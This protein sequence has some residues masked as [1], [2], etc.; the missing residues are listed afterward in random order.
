MMKSDYMPS[1]FVREAIFI[2]NTALKKGVLLVI[3][4]ALLFGSSALSQTVT[5]HGKVL[6][7]G[8][9]TN[10]DGSLTITICYEDGYSLSRTMSNCYCQTGACPTCGGMG[11]LLFGYPCMMC[12]GTG[13]CQ[14]CG[15]DGIMEVSF[16]FYSTGNSQG[17]NGNG[18]SKSYSGG[19]YS[20]YGGYS[21]G[22]SGSSRT[23]RTC[24]GC[25]GTG[26]GPDEIT[27][28]PNYTG[29]DNSRYCSQCGRVSPAHSHRQPMCRVCYGRG[30]VE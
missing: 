16:G 14:G 22:S 23:R 6:S 27:Y 15:G 1:C 12:Y 20:N 7:E 30:Y 24:L 8:K 17:G 25:G 26:K 2:L 19:T 10:A 28:A 9:R 5:N 18:N 4:F 11:T 29:K 13:R 21:N 3:F